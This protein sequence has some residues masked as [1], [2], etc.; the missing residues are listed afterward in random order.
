MFI[1][2]TIYVPVFINL[3]G[4][5]VGDKQKTTRYARGSLIL[6]GHKISLML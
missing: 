6:K 5:V 3:S 4:G 2:G 1:T